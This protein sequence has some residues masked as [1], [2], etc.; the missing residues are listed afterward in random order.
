MKND[1]DILLSLNP[2]KSYVPPK[3]PTLSEI[4][5]NTEL[6]KKL[7][8]RWKNNARII[9][10]LGIMGAGAV[11]LSACANFGR[12]NIHHGG[13]GFSPI[14][15]T[16]PTEQETEY[17][18]QYPYENMKQETEYANKDTYTYIESEGLYAESQIY[19]KVIQEEL[20]L[21]IHH[22]GSG[23]G[24]F[25]IVHLTEP[26][27]LSIIR[28]QLEQ[29]G[30][31]FNASP[32]DYHVEWWDTIGLDLFDEDKNIAVSHL[33]WED[34]NRHF[35]PTGRNFAEIISEEFERQTDDISIGVFY[36]PGETLNPLVMEGDQIRRTRPTPAEI[37]EGKVTA[38][39]IL[40]KRLAAQVQEFIG[41]LH[42]EG[43]I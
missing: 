2:V 19:T 37:E 34:S 32:P 23:S 25:Y 5:D 40:E 8:L 28:L 16:H 31:R 18:G 39:P 1:K 17:P 9:T 35:S 41:F 6:L 43:I 13:A 7:P 14:Y 24:P 22:G 3:I 29:A 38:R 42:S 15:V 26:E 20:N 12:P 4:Q 21:R 33:S 10:F 27:A 30:L 36:N 11:T